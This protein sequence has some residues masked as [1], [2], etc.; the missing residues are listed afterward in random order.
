MGLY[1]WS[2]EAIQRR[3]GGRRLVVFVD[4]LHL[5]DPVSLNV[6]AQHTATSEIFLVATLRSG[7]PVPELVDG[8]LSADRAVRV[9]L[10]VLSRDDVD[11]LL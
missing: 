9:D 6:L 1:H 7:E 10:D 3:A 5:L 11:R 2:R 8:L 4:D